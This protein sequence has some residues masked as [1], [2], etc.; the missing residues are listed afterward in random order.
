MFSTPSTLN[1]STTT[2]YE[3]KSTVRKDYHDDFDDVDLFRPQNHYVPPSTQP[4]S[5]NTLLPEP[6]DL[7]AD[8][9]GDQDVHSAMLSQQLDDAHAQ[10]SLLEKQLEKEKQEHVRLQSYSELQ[11]SQSVLKLK[12]AAEEM[13]R[14]QHQLKTSTETMEKRKSDGQ[15]FIQRFLKTKDAGK[16]PVSL[17]KA[18]VSFIIE[19][20]E[21]EIKEKDG[22]ISSLEQEVKDLSISLK[23]LENFEITGNTQMKSCKDE[24]LM[25]LSG[26]RKELQEK[27]TL[28]TKSTSENSKLSQQI[29]FLN[30][31]LITQQKEHAVVVEK[32]NAELLGRPSNQEF[33]LL[34]SKLA[35]VED[36]L[37]KYNQGKFNH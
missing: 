7:S 16:R 22:V 15:R 29:D 28:L 9:S 3:Q 4:F 30:K 1:S 27:E 37:Q 20:F 36:D 35:K 6:T 33:K 14:L 12:Q 10:I 31:S 18:D 25:E 24:L 11:V 32:L 34:Q 19:A 21:D 26:C 17:G 5:S 8:S 23:N 13:S 2:S